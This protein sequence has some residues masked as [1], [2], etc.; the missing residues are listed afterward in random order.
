MYSANTWV[1]SEP[2]GPNSYAKWAHLSAA[3]Q[4]HAAD[5]VLAQ[6]DRQLGQRLVEGAEDEALLV[7][8]QPPDAAQH[9][10][11]LAHP[12]ALDRYLHNAT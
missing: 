2:T 9:R 6:G 11:E 5:L 3:D 1:E 12:R 8:R 7:R 10:L 4:A